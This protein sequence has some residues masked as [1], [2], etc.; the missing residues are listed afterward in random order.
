MLRKLATHSI[1]RPGTRFYICSLSTTTIVY[2]VVF[3]ALKV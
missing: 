2:K 3:S 1:P